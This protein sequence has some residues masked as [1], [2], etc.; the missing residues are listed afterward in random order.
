MATKFTALQADAAE[1]IKCDSHKID[2]TH[3]HY[4]FGVSHN[5]FTYK[6]LDYELAADSTQA[7]IKLAIQTHLMDTNK[8]DPIPIETYDLDLYGV[9]GMKVGDL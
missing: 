6:W 1:L 4:L 2:G 7:D 5:G 9:E 3:D 8:Q